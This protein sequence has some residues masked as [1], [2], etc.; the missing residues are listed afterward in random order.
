MP[1]RVDD[2][3]VSAKLRLHPWLPG[4]PALHFGRGQGSALF[5]RTLHQSSYLPQIIP[6][7][8]CYEPPCSVDTLQRLTYGEMI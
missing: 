6:D 4:T 5:P 2:H 8:R 7:E 3:S 1:R